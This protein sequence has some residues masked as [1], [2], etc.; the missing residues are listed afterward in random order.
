[1]A[2][3]SHQQTWR[4]TLI[5]GFAVL[6]LAWVIGAFGS[7]TIE[8]R[9]QGAAGLALLAILAVPFLPK[10]H[11]FP[12]IP[13]WTWVSLAFL[14]LWS[15]FMAWNAHSEH[16]RE[17]WVFT[18][19]LHRPFPKAPG[20]VAYGDT[21]YFTFETIAIALGLIAAARCTE[22]KSWI[23]LLQIFA[24]AGLIVTFIALGHKILGMKTVWGM[25][26]TPEQVEQGIKIIHPETYFAPFI[27]NA[28][29]AAFLNLI[30]PVSLALALRAWK[31][32]QK[33]PVIFFWVLAGF[34]TVAGVIA[35]A[36]KGG[37]L[38]L[39][40]CL[41]LWVLLERKSLA[42]L[43]K[44]M[45]SGKKSGLENQLGIFLGGVIILGFIAMGTRHLFARWGTL[46]ETLAA[47]EQS[48]T[49]HSRIEMMKKMLHM[50]SPSEGSWHGFGP[51]SF[52]HLLPYYNPENNPAL[53]EALHRGH[54]D[55][56]Q[57]IVEWG[58]LGF[59]AWLSLGV[60]AVIA[61]FIMIRKSSISAANMPLVKALFIGLLGVG[62]HSCFDF[63]LSIF[64][65]HLV[66]IIYC[67]ILFSLRKQTSLLT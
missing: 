50:A 41:T 2:P 6:L 18:D 27:Y 19:F 4:H 51:G 35:A 31:R 58:Y 40:F 8:Y 5:A 42:L 46:A 9:R 64:S 49:V 33:T 34:I 29:A 26:A 60:G 30:F 48:G 37:F 53:R 32:K 65:I 15:S 43:L 56:L 13:I 36:S 59:F 38:I 66:A 67:G 28:N 22:S 57:T 62:A 52:P 24:V 39:L 10:H 3:F 63:P 17:I 23:I 20:A 7:S 1:M 47:N 55:P 12:V 16:N 44:K 54:C 45:R 21:Q 11:R 25:T 14:I 61:A